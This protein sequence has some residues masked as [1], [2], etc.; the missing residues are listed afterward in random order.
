ML[1]VLLCLRLHIFPHILTSMKSQISTLLLI[2]LPLFLIKFYWLC[3]YSCPDFYY[4]AC[5]HPTPPLP[6]AIPPTLIMSMGYVYKFFGYSISYNLHPHGDS[7]TTYLYFLIPSPLHP[8]I[9]IPLPSGNCQNTL[10]MHESVSVL[11]C[12]V[13]FLDSIDR[14]VFI[15]I[16]LFIVLIFLFFL[17]RSL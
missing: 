4:F 15:A 3:Y 11:V 14:Y 13:C 8:P 1:F 16:L 9:H 5:L 17:N 12:L 7:V 2:H 10:H 6:Q